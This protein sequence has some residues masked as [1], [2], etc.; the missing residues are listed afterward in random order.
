ME[1]LKIKLTYREVGHLR[2]YIHSAYWKAMNPQAVDEYL[3]LAEYLPRAEQNLIVAGRRDPLK[4][5]QYKM[6]LSVARIL[7]R[8]FQQEPLNGPLQDVLSGLD[9]EL[10]RRG[11]KP[12][13][14]KLFLS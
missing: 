2:D 11:L 1:P 6:P 7:H 10:L 8:R 5:Y 13:V 12:D 14:K 3:V 4:V 9:Y